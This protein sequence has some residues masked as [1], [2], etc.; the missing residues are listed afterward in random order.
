MRHWI[1]V[2]AATWAIA[3]SARPAHVLAPDARV[4]GADAAELSARWWQWASVAPP[5][6]R[7]YDD[8]SGARCADAQQGPV[9]FLAGTSGDAAVER[10]CSVP[11]GKYVFFPIITMLH[12]SPRGRHVPC[13]EVRA[14]AAVNNDHLQYAIVKIDGVVVP[15]AKR[16]RARTK[17]CFDVYERAPYVGNA[18]EFAPAA[19]DG[20]W[21]LLAPP[22]RGRHH[23]S[24]RAN[25]ANPA[26]G[27]AGGG[28]VQYFDYTI[29][30]VDPSI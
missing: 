11:Y 29:D 3:A 14:A 9:W 22:S 7:A 5:G 2:V 25:Y 18:G 17:A 20:Y 23:I 16:F 24:V 12:H 15:D 4:A 10:H 30:V 19:S 26:S 6:A 13:D 27:A 1:F 8:P 28:L 21:I